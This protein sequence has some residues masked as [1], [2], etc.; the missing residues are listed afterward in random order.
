MDVRVVS[1]NIRDLSGDPLAVQAV[2]R[3]LA[4]DVL[5]LQEAP[6]RP[7]SA[8]RIGA[9]ARSTGLRHVVGGRGSGGTA[10]LVGPAVTAGSARAVRFPVAHWYTR[11]RG[12]V[13][14]RLRTPSL[15]LAVACVHLP[16]GPADRVDHA[17]R[18]LAELDAARS[19]AGGS[20]PTVIAGD[21]NEPPGAPAWEAFAGL[22]G[23]PAPHAGPTFPARRPGGR[24]DAVLVSEQVRVLGYG[25]GGAPE[26]LVHRASDH[27][28][29]LA[30]LG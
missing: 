21:L 14:A 24:I 20:L 7:G 11:T 22:V 5:C 9:L 23:D 4:P 8:L 19:V 27:W 12:A 28:P 10:L 1:W 25:D 17:H 16:L 29:V 2:L 6:R 30:V 13:L 18:V 15:E 26:N 3:H